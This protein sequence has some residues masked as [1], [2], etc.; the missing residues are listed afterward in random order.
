MNHTNRNEESSL[1][2]NAAPMSANSRYGPPVRPSR[3]LLVGRVIIPITS[4][5]FNYFQ[6]L[7]FFQLF[8]LL[9]ITSLI[10]INIQFNIF[11]LFLLICILF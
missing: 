11:L 2:S 6:L 8:Q 3:R 4:I 1:I 7:Q 9:Y 5:L 10:F